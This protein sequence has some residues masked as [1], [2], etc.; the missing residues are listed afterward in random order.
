MT[1]NRF[2][3]GDTPAKHFSVKIGENQYI[4]DTP[5]FM[6]GFITGAMWTGV[7]HHKYWGNLIQYVETPDGI[8]DTPI[9]FQ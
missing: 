5:N 6:Q 8:I 4:F 7:D 2:M 3:F 1:G 9:I